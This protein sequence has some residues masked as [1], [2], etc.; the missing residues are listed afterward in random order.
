MK[1]ARWPADAS[2]LEL[3]VARPYSGPEPHF[4]SVGGPREPACRFVRSSNS[5]QLPRTIHNHR[6]A[7]VVVLD[8][9]VEESHLISRW[10]HARVGDLTL[11]GEQNCADRILEAL[12]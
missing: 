9:P 4:S 11:R 10:R 12:L 8:R 3:V 6:A 7:A 5:L 2:R 1:A